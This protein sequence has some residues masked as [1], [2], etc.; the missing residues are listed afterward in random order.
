MLDVLDDFPELP[1]AAQ[2]LVLMPVS[3]LLIE[4]SQRIGNYALYPQGEVDFARLRPVPNRDLQCDLREG[5]TEVSGLQRHR[6]TLTALTG[7]NIEAMSSCSI[8]AFLIE[9]DWEEFLDANHRGDIKLL[10]RLNQMAEPLLDII[11]YQFCRFDLPQSLPGRVGSWEGASPYWGALLYTPIDRESYLIA[12][13]STCPTA[14]IQGLEL[15]VN[16]PIDLEPPNGGEVASIASHAL[17]LFRDVLEAASETHRFTRAMTLIEF[18]A[19]PNSFIKM[20]KAKGKI[21]CHAARNK[22]DYHVIC[23]R[24]EELTG[25]EGLRTRIV[26]HGKFFEDILADENERRAIFRSG[27]ITVLG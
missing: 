14:V 25:D 27:F 13:P 6:E 19:R 16:S 23:G 1:G 3:R 17:T 10:S 15:E 26:H 11:R 9:L 4:V 20:Q 2:Q 21:A 5:E 8:M 12:G 7:F 18:L 22:E 24:F